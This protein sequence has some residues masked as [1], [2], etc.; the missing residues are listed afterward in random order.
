LILELST[1]YVVGFGIKPLYVAQ[2]WVS[3][4]VLLKPMLAAAEAQMF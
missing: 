3:Q 2:P 4:Y 1:G